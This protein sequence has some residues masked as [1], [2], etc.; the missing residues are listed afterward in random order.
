MKKK[1]TPV[2]Y[3]T[4]RQELSFD[5]NYRPKTLT[6]EQRRNRRTR[7]EAA[8]AAAGVPVKK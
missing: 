3:G 8:M 2:G 7:Y 5:P 4:G 1:T 6:P